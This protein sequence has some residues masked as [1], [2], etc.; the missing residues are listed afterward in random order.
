MQPGLPIDHTWSQGHIF[1][2]LHLRCL[3][4]S[5]SQGRRGSWEPGRKGEREEDA[6]LTNKGGNNKWNLFLWA[7]LLIRVLKNISSDLICWNVSNKNLSDQ[8]H[9]LIRFFQSSKALTK[10]SL[11]L[12]LTK[13]LTGYEFYSMTPGHVMSSTPSFLC[14]LIFL[15]NLISLLR[16]D[17]QLYKKTLLVCSFLSVLLA[18]LPH[19]TPS[20]DIPA[21]SQ[22]VGS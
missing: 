15:L 22:P 1:L 18:N 8:K 19:P 10:I 7:N 2:L 17:R 13:Y 21:K 3:K 9:F 5:G 14:G 4:L 12:W 16:M 20:S 11:W 6:C